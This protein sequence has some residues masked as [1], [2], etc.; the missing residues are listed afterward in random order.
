VLA[1]KY[2]TRYHHYQQRKGLGRRLRLSGMPDKGLDGC[3]NLQGNFMTISLA[4]KIN[5][6]IKDIVLQQNGFLTR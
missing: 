1:V 2:F 4:F 5:T 3:N 6:V